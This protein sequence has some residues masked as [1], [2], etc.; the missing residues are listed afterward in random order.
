VQLFAA[1]AHANDVRCDVAHTSTQVFAYGFDTDIDTCQA[2]YTS[3]VVQMVRACDLY[4]KTGR[5]RAA[6]VAAVTARLNFQLAFATRIGKRLA[7]V[8]ADVERTVVASAAPGTAVALRDK[9]LE[10]TDFYARTS[11]A[12][13]HWR[14]ARGSFGYAPGP[15][16]AGDR[17]GRAARLGTSPELPSARAQLT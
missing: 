14:G 8:K 6:G 9:E 4:L 16:L 12:R 17:A 11:A 15:A 13:G 2:L 3:L 7:T 10:L 1:I 5:H